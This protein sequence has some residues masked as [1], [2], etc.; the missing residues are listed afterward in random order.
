MECTD[1]VPMAC[2][3]G[4]DG[5]EV[6]CFIRMCGGCGRY[7]K[8]DGSISFNGLEQYIKQPNATC[9]K[10]GRVEMPSIGWCPQG[11]EDS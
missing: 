3:G 4:G 11:K 5:G 7:V 10:C 1:D 2:Y 8:A 9:S 6:Y